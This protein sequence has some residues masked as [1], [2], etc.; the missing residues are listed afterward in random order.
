MITFKSTPKTLAAAVC[1]SLVLAGAVV[2]AV[3]ADEKSKQHI[4]IGTGG[5]TGIYYT[6]GGA[7]CRL[8]K[9]IK[10]GENIDCRAEST[11]GSIYNLNSLLNGELDFAIVQADWHYQYAKDSEKGADLR[12]VLSLH[13][14]TFT[15][16]AH[17]DSEIETFND[18]KGK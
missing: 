10:T 14:E 18:L 3:Q 9:R 8:V 16:F 13:T 17:P 12:S 1:A 6:V 15:V 4:S 7:I 5:I 2:A 11:A